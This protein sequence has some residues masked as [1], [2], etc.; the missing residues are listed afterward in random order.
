ML[1]ALEFY[2]E[3]IEMKIFSL[4]YS[5]VTVKDFYVRLW[6]LRNPQ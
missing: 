6:L 4:N 5:V 3:N 1:F 2:C